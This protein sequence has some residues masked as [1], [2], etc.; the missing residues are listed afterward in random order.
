MEDGMT[1]DRVKIRMCII[2]RD[3]DYTR[4]WR[5][6]E[7]GLT[8]TLGESSIRGVDIVQVNNEPRGEKVILL[9]TVFSGN[10]QE[11]KVTLS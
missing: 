5:I 2:H 1:Y 10:P 11:E 9:R 7:M 6:C 8:K 4:V 3:F